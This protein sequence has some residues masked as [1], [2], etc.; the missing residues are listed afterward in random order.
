[1]FKSAD[2]MLK[3]LGFK[4]TKENIFGV[5]YEK[6]INEYNFTHVLSILSKSN[7]DNI[8]QSYEK[9]LNSDNHNNCVGITYKE[10]KAI[11]KKYREMKRKYNW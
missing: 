11:M 8:I 3:E 6:E 2:K 4:K 9:K 5:E 10:T 1:M 7:T